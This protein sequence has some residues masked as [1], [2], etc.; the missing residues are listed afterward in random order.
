MK[1]YKKLDI[2]EAKKEKFETKKYL[3]EMTLA[4]ARMN[5]A[6]RCKMTRTIQMNFKGD[7]R[8]RE[9][10]WKCVGCGE[11]DSQEHNVSCSAYVHLRTDKDKERYRYCQ[12][13]K[14]SYSYAGSMFIYS[15]PVRR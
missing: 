6:L 3:K 7:P 13:F 9:N 1:E 8:Y 10:K 14:A 11:I 5:F 12:I 2:N 15:R 4:D